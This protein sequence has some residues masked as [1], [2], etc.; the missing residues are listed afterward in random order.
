MQA[1]RER[2]RNYYS[3]RVG[4][5]GAT[6]LGVDWPS[7]ASRNHRFVQLLKIG[8]FGERFS[9]NDFGCGYGA[10]LAYLAWR[11]PATLIDYH[12]IDISQS[13]IEAAR[14]LWADNRL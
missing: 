11:H 9:L 5:F 1:I 2:V 8:D 3:D 6:P 13:M 14:P 10:L 12:G 7:V 4:K